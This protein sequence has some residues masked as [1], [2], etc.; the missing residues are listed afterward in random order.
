MGFFFPFRPLARFPPSLFTWLEGQ[1]NNVLILNVSIILFQLILTNGNFKLQR[2]VKMVNTTGIRRGT[3][4][5]FSRDFR[6]RGKFLKK[7]A[8][9]IVL[10]GISRLLS[11]CFTNLLP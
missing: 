6:K 8:L 3:R 9:L 5:M 4:Y 10:L 2:T 11:D 1:C 7:K